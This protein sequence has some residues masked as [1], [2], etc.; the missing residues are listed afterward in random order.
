MAK[1]YGFDETMVKK[2]II[3]WNKLTTTLISKMFNL[4]KEQ[5]SVSEEDMRKL[6]DTLNSKNIDFYIIQLTRIQYNRNIY[7]GHVFQF[8]KET[9]M[10][11]FTDECLEILK[12]IN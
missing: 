11:T 7:H 9:K 8:D 12:T 5:E 2:R 4:V 3:R 6:L 10:F 1:I